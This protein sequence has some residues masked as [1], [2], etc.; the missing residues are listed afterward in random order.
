MSL[1]YNGNESPIY[2][3]ATSTQDVND[4]VRATVE[5]AII[6]ADHS[7]EAAEAEIDKL[8]AR[9]DRLVQHRAHLRAWL[10]EN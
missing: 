6:G 10:E 8:R 1:T 2:H 3:P 7:I 9:R 4:R 5:D